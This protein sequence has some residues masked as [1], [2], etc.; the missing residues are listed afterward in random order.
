MVVGVCVVCMCLGEASSSV[1]EGTV[2]L[3]GVGV[4]YRVSVIVCG[5]SCIVH[6]VYVL[7]CV[8]RHVWCLVCVLWCVV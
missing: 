5:A 3:A 6:L 1:V 2:L 4:A 7:W 8:A